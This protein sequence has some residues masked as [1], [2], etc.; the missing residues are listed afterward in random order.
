MHG[1]AILF[2]LDLLAKELNPLLILPWSK[3]HICFEGTSFLLVFFTVLT[4]KSHINR[5][6][7]MIRVIIGKTYIC[8]SQNLLWSFLKKQQSIS[9]FDGPSSS[10]TEWF[11]FTLI[12]PPPPHLPEFHVNSCSHGN[13][14]SFLIPDSQAILAFIIIY[15]T[16]SILITVPCH[17]NNF[18]FLHTCK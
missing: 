9:T 12:I 2:S 11:S 15:N 7:Q 18:L 17:W 6:Q 14:F 8:L 10:V 1:S 16:F 13:P 5:L 4:L 3:F